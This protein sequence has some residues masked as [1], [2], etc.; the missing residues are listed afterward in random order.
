MFHL[1]TLISKWKG[2]SVNQQN[3]RHRQIGH[4][5]ELEL[6]ANLQKILLSNIKQTVDAGFTAAHGKWQKLE[7]VWQMRFKL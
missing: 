6:I 4:F 1:R 2:V 5:A 3:F 7:N